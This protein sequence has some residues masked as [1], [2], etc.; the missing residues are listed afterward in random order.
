MLSFG[1]H[2]WGPHDFC[3]HARTDRSQIEQSNLCGDI[4]LA[5]S[6]QHTGA[7]EGTRSS[8]LLVQSEAIQELRRPSRDLSGPYSGSWSGPMVQNLG[9]DH[10]ASWTGGEVG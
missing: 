7:D 6:L 8:G 2:F 1:G 9:V 4:G 10:R 3:N 5:L